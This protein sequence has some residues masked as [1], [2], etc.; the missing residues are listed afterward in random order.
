MKRCPMCNAYASND[1]TTCFE[2]MYSFEHM[3]P[4]DKSRP[5]RSKGPKA[6]TFKADPRKSNHRDDATGASLASVSSSRPV[7]RPPQVQQNRKTQQT[8]STSRA[9]NL[10]PKHAS[11]REEQSAHV[12]KN[13]PSACSRCAHVPTIKI[14]IDCPQA[15]VLIE[16]NKSPTS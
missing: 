7:S 13:E 16:G 3:T 10:A 1:A 12:R 11:L 8:V 15:D 2:C 14:V 9:Q 5:P 4:L 6:S